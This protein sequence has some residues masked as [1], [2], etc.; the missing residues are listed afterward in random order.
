MAY[1]TEVHEDAQMLFHGKK[2]EDEK[3]E[4]AEIRKVLDSVAD[5]DLKYSEI[6]I[7]L[8]IKGTDLVLKGFVDLLALYPD[9]VVIHD[10]KTDS[11]MDSKV[12][13]EYKLQ[14]SVYAIAASEY[15]GLPA[16]CV[17]DYVS[18]G[19]RTAFSPLPMSA[20]EERVRETTGAE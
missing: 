6:E 20:I 19:K 15:Y 10:Y 13:Y 16:E 8:P 11:V 1:G 12:E 4:H 2:P 17:I 5:A 18:L 9:K 14:L 7:K 3:K